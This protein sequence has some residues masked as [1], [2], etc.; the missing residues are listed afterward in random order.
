MFGLLTPDSLIDGFLVGFICGVIPLYFS[1]GKDRLKLGFGAVAACVISGL[2]L[3]L[4]LALPIG[5]LFLAH[6]S[7]ERAR[8]L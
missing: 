7:P 1:T 5:V 6:F 3:G 8:A 4:L 2:L